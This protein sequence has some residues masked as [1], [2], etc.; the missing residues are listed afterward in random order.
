M[1]STLVDLFNWN[2][3]IGD[4]SHRSC[5]WR[6][7]HIIRGI[8]ID[9][10]DGIIAQA[11][12]GSRLDL[13]GQE[14]AETTLNGLVTMRDVCAHIES[15]FFV[16]DREHTSSTFP[17]GPFCICNPETGKMLKIKSLHMVGGPS[18]SKDCHDRL[19]KDSAVALPTATTGTASP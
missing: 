18:A 11:K 2:N 9:A 15:I 1:E 3:F 13:T 12:H 6:R 5:L 14:F 17:R 8:T 16:K 4:Y 10:H 19:S 7:H